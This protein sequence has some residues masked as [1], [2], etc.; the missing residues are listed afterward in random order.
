MN[1]Q[2]L[3]LALALAAAS[4]LTAAAP[5]TD[6]TGAGAESTRL[7]LLFERS[8]DDSARRSPEWATFRG[9]RRFDH[10]FSDAS[11]EAAAAADAAVHAELAAAR[12][13]RREQLPPADQLSLDLFV[14]RAE[15]QVAMMAFDG[16]R[17]QSISSAFGFQSRLAGLL[18][19]MPID[20]PARGEQVLARLAAWPA[21]LAQ[22]IERVRGAVAQGWVPARPVLERAL[23]QLDAQLAA[24]VR[25]G[26]YFQPLRDMSPTL[27]A[28]LQAALRS[29]GEAAITALVLPAQRSLRAF[30]ADEMLPRAPAAGGLAHYPGGEALDAALVRER[31]TT[32]LSPAE[33]HAI[34]LRE[35]ARLRGEF[36]RVQQAMRFEGS[37][38]QFVAHLNGPQYFYASPEAML[39]GYRALAKRL[40][41]EMPALFAE[42]PRL[43]YGIRP[44]PA[45]LGAGAA[46]S[47]NGPPGDGSGPGWYNA[48]TQAFQRR[49]RWALPTLVA[50]ETAPGHHLQI[51]RARELGDLPDF[52][53]LGGYTAF[54]E[55]WALYA[56]TLGDRFGLYDAPEDRFGHL[57]AQAFRAARLVVDTGLHAMGWSRQRAIDYMVQE[58]G[59]SPVFIESEV[60]RYLSNP[61]QALAYM[62]GKLKFDELRDR[63]QLRL[64]ARFDLRRFHNAVLDAGALPLNLL[65]RRIDDWIVAQPQG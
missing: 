18:Q 12:A 10:R 26:P 2:T 32:T 24:P 64:G 60:D 45:F 39:T 30:I 61:A 58:V 13:I 23:A 47:Y 21:R 48:N 36:T 43:P 20:T 51:A 5:A 3:T 57:Q 54:S 28:D 22:E 31:T 29:R 65:E 62:I 37:F 8:W 11:P 16:W 59:E 41:P 4:P 55:G 19:A 49:P 38:T 14:D 27:P 40:D 35:M 50:H 25:T 9:D 17:R 1:L 52:R 6:P 33:V 63:A 34:G 46:D 42:L 15:R 44:M 53:R 56:E 7:H